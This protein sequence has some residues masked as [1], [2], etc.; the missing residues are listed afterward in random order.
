MAAADAVRD[1]FLRKPREERARAWEQVGRSFFD[2][3]WPLDLAL[4]N[5]GLSQHL[6]RLPSLLGT[7]FADGVRT[8]TPLI[9][10]FE[11]WDVNTLF[12]YFGERRRTPEGQLLPDSSERRKAA[13]EDWNGTLD[14]LDAVL[15]PSPAVVSHDLADWLA[16][17]SSLVPAVA[18]DP[19]YKRLLRLTQR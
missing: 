6:A 9:V 19:R 1:W 15:G 10:P 11:L 2:Q 14:L 8:I 3:C 17:I 18:E 5:P 12:L 4:R 13:T 16:E 7:A